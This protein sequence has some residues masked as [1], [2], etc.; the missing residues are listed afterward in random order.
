M[1]PLADGDHRL[2]TL[3][4]SLPLPTTGAAGSSDRVVPAL[5]ALLAAALERDRLQAEV[6]ETQALRRSDE[7]K[8][9]LL[10]SV[11]HDL[12]TPLTA[13]ITAGAGARRRRPLAHAT[14]SELGRAI[15]EEARG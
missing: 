11:S 13:I 4:V 14:A 15:V 12:R 10:R 1:F 7:L 2:G 5:D 9:A 3:V 6:V 8:T